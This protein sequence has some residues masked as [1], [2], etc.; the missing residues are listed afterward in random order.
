[1]PLPR[2][3]HVALHWMFAPTRADLRCNL[4]QVC[5]RVTGVDA[6]R[7]ALEVADRNLPELNPSLKA[8]VYRLE[9]DAFEILLENDATEHKFDTIVLDQPAFAKSKRATEGALR[10]YKE[11]NLRALRMLRPG[12]RLITCSCSNHV[13]LAD[14][15]AVVASAAADAGRTAQTLE[16]RGAA[17]D[18]PEIL[19]LPE[20][21]YLKCLVVEAR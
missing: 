20:T 14:F 8:E 2:A 17:L 21:A 1:M 5:E 15:S 9:A 4:A 7:A 3:G 11:L 18:H 13:S 12:G 6:S 16:V 10:G 19:T